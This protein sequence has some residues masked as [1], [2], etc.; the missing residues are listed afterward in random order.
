MVKKGFIIDN[1][2]IN[3]S[4]NAVNKFIIKIEI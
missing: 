3:D 1:M 2:R 4:E